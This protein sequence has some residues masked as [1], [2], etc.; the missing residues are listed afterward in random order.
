MTVTEKLSKSTASHE[1][2]RQTNK[3]TGAV[4]VMAKV[5][6]QRIPIMVPTNNG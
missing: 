6:L 1:D 4:S 5:K 3:S 2:K